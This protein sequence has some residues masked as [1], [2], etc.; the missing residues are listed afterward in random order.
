MVIQNSKGIKNYPYMHV[1]N[2]RKRTYYDV[3]LHR[4]PG[5]WIV[6]KKPKSAQGKRECARR[7]RQMRRIEFRKAS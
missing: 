2:S 6:R 1:D 4:R 3:N 5:G 7:V